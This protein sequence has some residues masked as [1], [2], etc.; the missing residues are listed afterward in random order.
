MRIALVGF[1]GRMGR[2]IYEV[3]KEQGHEVIGIDLRSS[4]GP[5]SLRMWNSLWMW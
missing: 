4:D 3:A 2:A 5:A 1:E